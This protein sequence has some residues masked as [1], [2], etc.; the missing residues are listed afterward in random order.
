MVRG[1]L[2]GSDVPPGL[3]VDRDLRWAIVH[4]L[5]AH[6]RLD[7]AEIEAEL[8]RD[9]SSAGQRSAATA[10]AL[11]PTA[12]AKAEAWRLATADDDLPNAMQRAVVAGFAHPTQGPLLKPYVERYFA[13]IPGVW[14]RRT[15]EIAQTVVL[16]LFPTWPATI[17]EATLAAAD[18]FLTREEIPSAL[19]RLVGEGRADVAR[20]LTA[21]RADRPAD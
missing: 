21:R 18:H 15:S 1:L 14:E 2:D 3:T 6:G 19:R 20:A 13:D 16:G 8:A 4:T 11:R 9:P 7:D 17:S 12:E 5:A 10:R